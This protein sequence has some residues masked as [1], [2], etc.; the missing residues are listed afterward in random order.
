[1]KVL[2]LT[3]ALMA[4]SELVHAEHAPQPHA[5]HASH[6]PVAKKDEAAKS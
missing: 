4:G 1:M 2:A 3:L 6:A 5:P